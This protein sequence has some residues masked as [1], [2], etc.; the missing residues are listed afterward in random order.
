MR[1]KKNKNSPVPTSQT[2]SQGARHRDDALPVV[3]KTTSIR[4]WTTI[5]RRLH[6]GDERCR[7]L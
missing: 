3:K 6:N 2:S 4:N 1:Y 7:C 5:K